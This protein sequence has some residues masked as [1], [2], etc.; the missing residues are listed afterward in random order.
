MQVFSKVDIGKIR[1]TNQDAADAFM[2]ADNVA[3]AICCDGMGGAK[4]GD[5]ASS[6]ALRIISDYV[7]NSF[8]PNMS[9]E[10]IALLLKNAV[11]SANYE[12]FDISKSDPVLSGMGTTVVA[13]IVTEHYAVICHVGDSRAYL[14]NDNIVQLTVDHSVVQSLIE[15]GKISLLEARTFPEKNVITKALGV[16]QEVIPDCSVFSVGP[17]DVILLCSDG[18]TNFVEI[19][20]ILNSFKEN[21]IEDVPEVL[22]NKANSGGGGDNISV[23]I[24][25][26]KRG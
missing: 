10:Q 7:K 17:D 6:N 25:S 1:A 13:A 12:V 24:V 16:E 2:L 14:I 4:G 19:S 9:N 5:I 18:L 21:E 23:V 15:S 20:D 22:I 3:F 11:L 26:Q 8:S